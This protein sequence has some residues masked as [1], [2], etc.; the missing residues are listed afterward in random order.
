MGSMATGKIRRSLVWYIA[1]RMHR[2][3]MEL[4]AVKGVLRLPRELTNLE[5]RGLLALFTTLCRG[6][7]DLHRDLRLTTIRQDGCC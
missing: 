1:Y 3:R 7:R 6:K 4:N 2:D 5:S